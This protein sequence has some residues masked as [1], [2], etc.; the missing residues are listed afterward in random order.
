M[1]ELGPT[2]ALGNWSATCVDGNRHLPRFLTSL[3]LLPALSSPQLIRIF[4]HVRII[5]VSNFAPSLVLF[6]VTSIDRNRSLYLKDGAVK[7]NRALGNRNVSTLALE[8]SC[9]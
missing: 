4:D 8:L 2:E 9:H 5:L 7:P 1:L 3:L 6:L